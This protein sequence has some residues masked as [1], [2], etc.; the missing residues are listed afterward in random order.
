VHYHLPQ[1]NSVRLKQELFL[2]GIKQEI[3]DSMARFVLPANLTADYLNRCLERRGV[4]YLFKGSIR[5]TNVYINW[6][7]RIVHLGFHTWERC[8][9][10]PS[11][12][13]ENGMRLTVIPGDFIAQDDE[14]K[15]QKP[16]KDDHP[17]SDSHQTISIITREQKAHP[18]LWMY[19]G[20]HLEGDKVKVP[21]E[22]LAANWDIVCFTYGQSYITQATTSLRRTG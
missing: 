14:S 22:E 3:H 2:A 21:Y 7:D 8:M 11:L 13:G 12:P 17:V 19:K 1:Q 9:G 4:S 18:A 10:L 20:E 16:P 15:E 6:R 5:E